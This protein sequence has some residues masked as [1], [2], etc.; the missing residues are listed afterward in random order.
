MA[1][2][3]HCSRFRRRTTEPRDFRSCVP[4][5]TRRLAEFV[6]LGLPAVS[7]PPSLLQLNL[8]RLVLPSSALIRQSTTLPHN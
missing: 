2:Q 4:F 3:H 6:S 5:G 7:I 1:H 8:A